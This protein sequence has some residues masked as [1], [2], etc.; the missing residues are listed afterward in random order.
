[1]HASGSAHVSLPRFGNEAV[2]SRLTPPAA[3][4]ARCHGTALRK[5][6]QTEPMRF[7]AQH[8]ELVVGQRAD[9]R[10]A[11]GNAGVVLA[12]ERAL[13]SNFENVVPARHQHALIDR[14]GTR[15]RRRLRAGRA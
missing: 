9:Q 13:R 15:R 3:P 14:D 1:M 7:A 12:R 2:A 4:D 8:F 6:A 10:R 11:L 5:S